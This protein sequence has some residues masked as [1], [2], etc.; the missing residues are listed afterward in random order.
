MFAT[1]MAEKHAGLSLEKLERILGD[2]KAQP[3]WR[4]EANRAAAYYDGNQ[5]EPEV[6]AAMEERGQ[7]I[8][9]GSNVGGMKSIAQE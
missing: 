6:A 8:M 2:I 9:A 1:D 3:E 5:I 7:P 4:S